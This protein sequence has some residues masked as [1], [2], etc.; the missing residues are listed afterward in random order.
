MTANQLAKALGGSFN[1]KWYNICGPGHGSGDR[2]L[3]FRFDPHEPYGIRISSFAGDDPDICRHHI[4]N[5]LSSLSEGGLSAVEQN[6]PKGADQA[7]A[8]AAKASLIWHA[9]VG[10]VGTPAENYLAS[11]GCLPASL[12]CL[13]DAVRCHPNCPMGTAT[14]PAMV[15]MM[16]DV[17][18]GQPTG[19]HR[20]AL[21]DDGSAKRTM[22]SRM[23]A[24]MMLG[25][26][27][28]AAV[29]LCNS[30]PV[31]GIAEGI[32]TALSAQKIFGM[33]V[34]ACM[35]APGIAGFPALHGL[36]HLTI[37][38]DH[39]EAGILA[40]RKCA[41]RLFKAGINGGMKY[42]S[43]S[44]DDWNCYLQKGTNNVS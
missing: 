15:S 28:G 35:S 31:M 23:P 21:A 4:I 30:A 18:T 11:R 42:P 33:P 8:N 13:T 36:N 9:A 10:A 38:A 44:G 17:I 37:F 25:R 40:A 14:V 2:S 39:D 6:V 7:D 32:E 16:R 3:G 43:S 29:V 19:I 5:K 24:K 1:G 22:P 26:A 34:W 20:T 12:A 27:K 41:A